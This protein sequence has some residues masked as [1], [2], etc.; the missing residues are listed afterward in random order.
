M[1]V[2]ILFLGC[3]QEGGVRTIRGEA[4]G[5]TYQISWVPEDAI[6]NKS[7][8]DSLLTQID[9]SLSTYVPES[10]ISR[11][12]RNDSTV[13]T[14]T[15]FE[16]V[17]HAARVISENTGGAFD[18]TVA[19]LVNI[20]GFGFTKKAF[21]DSSTIDS[22]LRFVGYEKVRLENKKLIK[23]DPRTMIDFNAIAQGYTVD[24]LS[25]WVKRKG[26][27]NYLI[28]LGGEVRAAGKK[29][30]D[31]A[32]RIGID[33]P[34]DHAIPGRELQAVI[35][36]VDRSLATSGN[37]RKFYI[38]DGKRI[39]HII[40]PR[41]GYPAKQQLLSATVVAKDC[42]I[43]DA[44]ATAFMVMGLEKAKAFLASSKNPGLEVFFIYDENGTWKTFS[45]EK[46][47][48]GLSEIH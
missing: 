35:E 30:R 7:D 42:M 47:R 36:L 37:Y 16:D 4:Q 11:I 17:Y 5:T 14:D 18:I 46:L 23:E 41:T 45:S 25:E 48:T 13:T 20:R 3:R 15:Y 12:N 33:K 43:A 21:V 24:V 29:N 10:I 31:G 8:I 34:T 38:E 32:W 28:E 9:L 19:P 6:L 39:S 27:N 40:D 44:Y 22:I 2:F 26:V 1:L